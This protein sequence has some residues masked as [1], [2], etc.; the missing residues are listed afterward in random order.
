MALVDQFLKTRGGPVAVGK[1]KVV[2]MDRIPI[3]RGKVT[4]TF[5]RAVVDQGVALKS[6]KGGIRL[7]DGRDV[8]LLNIW[9][10]P[11]LPLQV[12]HDV[13]CPDGGLR[14]W[15]IYRVRHPNGTT[16][17]DAWT[18]NA[19]MIVEIVGSNRRY[20]RCSDGP[21]EFDPAFEFEI[22]WAEH[23]HDLGD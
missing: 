7:S 3:R 10:E 19:G 23:E 14:V 2:Q 16:T 12:E 4:V 13:T 5:R 17:E 20:Y 9:S 18:G 8:P 22:Q 15:N 1:N 11:N 6:A 21:G